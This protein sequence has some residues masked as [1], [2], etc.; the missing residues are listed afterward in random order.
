[1]RRDAGFTLIETLAVLAVLAAM[2]AAA[3]AGLSRWSGPDLQREAARVA[4][5]LRVARAE[6]MTSSR[7]VALTLSRD[8][9]VS[10][11]GTGW[12]ETLSAELDFGDDRVDVRRVVFDADGRASVGRVAL[13]RGDRT[14]EITLDP[15]TGRAAHGQ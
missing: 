9:T 13:R 3:A 8:G 14:V 10:A 4:N 15:M 12:R 6:A 2:T 5:A 7:P 11:P 1:M